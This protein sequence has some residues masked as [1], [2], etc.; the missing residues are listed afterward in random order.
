[1]LFVRVYRLCLCFPPFAATRSPPLLRL[2]GNSA[3]P[4][5]HLPA[6]GYP[7][8]RRV[9]SN[10]VQNQRE[11]CQVSQNEHLRQSSYNSR[12]MNTYIKEG[13]GEA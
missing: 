3:N 7:S 9:T 4:K 5:F 6:S 2:S 12:E 13:K 11:S 10:K 1:M 8:G